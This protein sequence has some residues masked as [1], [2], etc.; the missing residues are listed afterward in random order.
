MMS[1]SRLKTPSAARVP[2][3]CAGASGAKMPPVVRRSAPFD[4]D[5]V[6][7]FLR[8]AF[9]TA[10]ALNVQAETGIPAATVDNWLR[11][12]AAPSAAHMGLLIDRFGPAI[13]SAAYPGTERWLG[14]QVRRERIEKAM[15]ELEAALS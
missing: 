4:P 11:G 10:T 13:L 5:S 6:V 15:A 9:P 2:A 1:S 14:G 8:R 7:T 3:H 12:R